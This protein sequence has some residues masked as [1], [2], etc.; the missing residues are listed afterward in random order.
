MAGVRVV[1]LG[2]GGGI[3]GGA[4]FVGINP[5]PHGGDRVHRRRARTPDDVPQRLAPISDQHG[6][7]VKLSDFAGK[8]VLM[9]WYPKAATPG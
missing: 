6:E 5:P 8:W 2:A 3:K 1:A 7:P 4:G 9:W